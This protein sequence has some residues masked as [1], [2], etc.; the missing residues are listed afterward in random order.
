MVPGSTLG[1]AF[2]LGQ[3]TS[4]V[5]G[6]PGT[7]AFT[8]QIYDLHSYALL[9]SIVIPNVIGQPIQMVRWGASG[10]AF[11]T[12]NG[13]FEGDNAPGLTYILSGSEISKPS[14]AARQKS[15]GAE[16]VRL[17]WKP[18]KTMRSTATGGEATE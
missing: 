13:D 15:A 11:T 7:V 17:T 4:P 5:S 14:A 3:T 18:G 1:L 10:I 16:H 2:F 8:L 12:E 6:A 9:D